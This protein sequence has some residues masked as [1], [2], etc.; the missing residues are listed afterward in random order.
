MD[1]IH[2]NWLLGLHFLDIDECKDG[3]NNCDT[4]ANCQNT[5]GSYTCTCKTGYSGDGKTCTGK[6]RKKPAWYIVLIPAGMKTYL[7]QSHSISN[8]FSSCCL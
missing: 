8:T 1:V 6:E 5:N 4:N 2:F 7:W 3:S